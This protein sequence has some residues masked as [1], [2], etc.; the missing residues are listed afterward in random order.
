[1]ASS[2]GATVAPATFVHHIYVSGRV[3]GVFYRKY[4]AQTAMRLGLTGYVQNLEDGRV[5]VMAEGTAPQLAALEEWCHKGSPKAKVS[6][7]AV[8]DVT[9]R[10]GQ[11]KAAPMRQRFST[12]VVRR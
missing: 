3:Q 8:T 4:T 9:E 1:M 7:V 11:S 6:G 12:F 5:E 2:G 10:D